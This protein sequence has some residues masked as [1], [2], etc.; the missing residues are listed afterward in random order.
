MKLKNIFPVLLSMVIGVG[1]AYFMFNQYDHEENLNLVSGN[2]EKTESIYFLQQGVY[3]SRESMENN[4]KNLAYYLYQEKDGMFYV[5]VGLTKIEENVDKIKGY[6]ERKGYNLY[7]KQMEVSSTAFLDTLDQYDEL[8]KQTTEDEAINTICNNII[9]KYKE[10]V[11]N[12]Q[13]EG[14]TQE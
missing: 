12:D 8:L 2:V 5:F 6:Y 10:L 9:T 13:N 4:T 14:D 7:S 1:F 11:M 3:S